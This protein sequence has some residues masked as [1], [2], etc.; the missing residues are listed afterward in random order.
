MWIDIKP[1]SDEHATSLESSVQHLEETN[2][3]LREQLELLQP[4]DGRFFEGNAI[5]TDVEEQRLAMEKELI[6]LKARRLLLCV[7]FI[8]CRFS[9]ARCRPTL[10]MRSSS[11]SSCA[12]KCR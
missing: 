8:A 2:R 1:F 12:P 9:M 7:F 6:S 5:F 4:S 3:E 11:G 10:T